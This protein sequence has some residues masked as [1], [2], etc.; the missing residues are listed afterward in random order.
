MGNMPPEKNWGADSWRA[1]ALAEGDTL[2]YDECGRVLDKTCYRSHYFRLVLDRCS[3][4]FLLV[5]HGAGDERL[6]LGWSKRIIDALA[7]VDSD[8][9]YFL[10]HTLYAR[11]KD[12][13]TGARDDTAMEYKR[14]FVDGRLK[15]RKQRRTGLYK[16]WI[17]PKRD[18]LSPTT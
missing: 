10:L 14:A 16:V 11:T 15:K 5:R 6:K 3:T 18:T 8:S 4:P 7:G 17:E 13:A 1:P 2:I 9:R 12:A